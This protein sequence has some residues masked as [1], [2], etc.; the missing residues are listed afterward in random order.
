M[1]FAP[2]YLDVTSGNAPNDAEVIHKSGRADVGT[3]Y[4]PICFGGIYR[5][6]Q[7]GAATTLRVK[8][9]NV[10]DTAGGSGARR[11]TL[12]GINASGEKVTEIL[13]TAGTS[14]SSNSIHSYIRLYR[15]I[16][17]ESGTYATTSVGSHAADVIIENSAGIEDWAILD[18]TDYPRG[19]SEIAAFTVPEGQT[20]YITSI[21]ISVD[22]TK[23]ADILLMQRTDILLT[24]A[25]YSAMR[26]IVE[27][28][29]VSGEEVVNPKSPYGPYAAGTDL[30]FLG[31]VT[32]GTAEADVDFEILLR[33]NE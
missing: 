12:I 33:N 28:G 32:S 15:V 19:Q 14:A 17:C 2:Y 18:V 21:T 31:K 29:G 26:I 23:S 7:V 25:P 1:S 3:S 20:G 8:A 30:I 11:V 9:G 4:T 16:V 22:S 13:T 6:P 24:S 5:T 27:L 10:N